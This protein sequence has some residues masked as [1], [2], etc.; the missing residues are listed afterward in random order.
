[1]KE[2]KKFFSILII[3]FISGINISY[4]QQIKIQDVHKAFQ[5][6]AYSYYMR[7]KYIQYNSPKVHH[8]SPEEAT[9]Q[10]INY[11]V[12][13]GFTRSVYLELLNITTP[14]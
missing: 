13:A 8:F 9:S 1:M 3:A 10:N 4:E 7:G 11:M 5:E 14:V 12:C 2:Y 6:V